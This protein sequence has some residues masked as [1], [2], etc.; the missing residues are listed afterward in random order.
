MVRTTRMGVAVAAL[1]GASLLL[2]GAGTAQASPGGK[3]W[4]PGRGGGFRMERPA[5]RAF[6][7][8]WRPWGGGRIYRDVIVIRSTR[9]P[10]Y[11]AWRTYAP[12]EYIYSRR[13]IRVRPIRFV[14]AGVFGGVAIRG[15]WH[16]DGYIYGCNF[17]DARF[18]TYDAYRAHVLTCSHRPRGYRV[19]CNDWNGA[20]PWDDQGWRDDDGQGGDCGPYGG[21]HVYDRDRDDDRGYGRDDRGYDRDDQG[22]GRDDRDDDHDRWNRNDRDDDRDRSYRNDR[23]DEDDDD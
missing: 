18:R 11:R 6:S 20:G 3:W 9:Y 19:E 8:Q 15:S 23:D 17:C 10:R 22:Y 16:D 12:P 2:A 7:R 1:L 14:V 13:L 4:N 21:Y 5:P